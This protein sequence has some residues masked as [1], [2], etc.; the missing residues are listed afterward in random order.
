MLFADATVLPLWANALLFTVASAAVWIAGTGV[1][2]RAG[3]IAD[4]TKLDQAFVGM[5]VLGVITSL[6][7]IA[8][9]V[10]SSYIGSPALAVNNVLGSASINMLIL[11]IADVAIGRRVALT[12]VVV[13]PGTMLQSALCMIALTLVA[14]A[15]ST[16]DVAIP[17]LGAGAWSIVIA[18]FCAAAFGLSARYGRRAPW[19]LSA[20]AAE[21]APLLTGDP[22]G[23]RES[24]AL[25]PLIVGTAVGAAVILVA[26]FVLA[27]SGDALAV[28]TGLGTSMV[29]FLLIG[30]ATSLPELSTITATVR[31]G[32]HDMAIG[33]ILGT[34]FANLTLILVADLAFAGGPVIAELGRFEIVSSLLGVLLIGAYLVGLL[35][36]R[37]GLIL[38]MGYDSLA[39]MLLFAAGLGLLIGV[40]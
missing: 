12:A 29:G 6:P 9:V 37:A 39:V 25:R 24:T 15:V 8:N 5:F 17:G 23:E 4:V 40:G 22:A 19:E 10:T 33:E 3:R 20:A 21:A 28:Q 32:R 1:A 38:R 16:G 7:E 36:R 30:I 34:N 31:M 2:R 18:V 11:A 26:G 14:I 13:G 35:E 27:Q